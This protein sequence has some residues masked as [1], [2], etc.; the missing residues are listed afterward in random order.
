MTSPL[1]GLVVNPENACKNRFTCNFT[2]SFNV[3]KDVNKHRRM[4]GTIH[5]LS[6]FDN[7]LWNAVNAEIVERLQ[8]HLNFFPTLIS[9]EE[10]KNLLFR[11]Y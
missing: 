6:P 10:G 11:H 8:C 4:G 2:S 1:D 9:L 7:K 3:S 5:N